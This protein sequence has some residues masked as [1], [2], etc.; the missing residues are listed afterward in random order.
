MK[1]LYYIMLFLVFYSC[2]RQP[3]QISSEENVLEEPAFQE[4]ENSNEVIEK[5]YEMKNISSELNEDFIRQNLEETLNLIALKNK[6]ELDENLARELNKAIAEKV[7]SNSVNSELGVLKVK[8]LQL[9]DEL[10]SENEHHV[11]ITFTAESTDNKLHEGT[12]TATVL[13][14]TVNIDG[15]NFTDYKINF[16]EISVP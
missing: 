3:E 14:D 8:N 9:Q 11:S 7:A 5:D 10:V 2:S 12:A 13:A 16:S 6:M 1:T 4:M 15:E